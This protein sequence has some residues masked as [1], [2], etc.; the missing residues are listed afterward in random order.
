MSGQGYPSWGQG[1][2]CAGE[3]P[4]KP[5]GCVGCSSFGR[6]R[7]GAPNNVVVGELTLQFAAKFK[8]ADVSKP[9]FIQALAEVK[10]FYKRSSSQVG[11]FVGSMM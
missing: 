3:P 5:L 4:S 10:R 1:A 9:L 8:Q 11:N 7:E 2:Q 6:C